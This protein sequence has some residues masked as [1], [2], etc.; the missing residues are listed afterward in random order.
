MLTSPRLDFHSCLPVQHNPLNRQ[1]HSRLRETGFHSGTNRREPAIPIT[2]QAICKTGT[3]PRTLRTRPGNKGALKEKCRWPT[4]G[5]RMRWSR[6][7]GCRRGAPSHRMRWGRSRARSVSVAKFQNRI[8][9]RRELVKK[10]LGT[11]LAARIGLPAPRQ[12]SSR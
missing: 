4:A 11:Y 3:G 10:L 12:P 8:Q 1:I 5:S 7:G 9:H 6:Y 2:N